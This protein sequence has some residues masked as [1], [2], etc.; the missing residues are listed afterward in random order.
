MVNTHVTLRTGFASL[1]SGT[2]S[3]FFCDFLIGTNSNLKLKAEVDGVS[4]NQCNN[5]YRQLN[6]VLTSKQLCA[7][8]DATG[9]DSCRGDSGGPIMTKHNPDEYHTYYYLAGLVSFGLSPCGQTGWPGVY[10]VHY[11]ISLK[12]GDKKI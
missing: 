5:V 8:G 1:N 9:R 2:N 3:K 4:L 6:V 11:F 10:T 12:N 7:G